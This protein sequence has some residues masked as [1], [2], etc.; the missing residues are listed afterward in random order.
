MYYSGHLGKS[1]G[2]FSSKSLLHIIYQLFPH[3]SKISSMF[4]LY[5]RTVFEILYILDCF[6]TQVVLVVYLF[7]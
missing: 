4:P 1:L 5:K 2:D 6:P 3:I 7:I